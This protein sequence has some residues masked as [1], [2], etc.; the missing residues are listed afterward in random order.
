MIIGEEEADHIVGA[1]I[2]EFGFEDG[3]IVLT[4]DNGRQLQLGA[5]GSRVWFC[6]QEYAVH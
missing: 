4:L 5:S 2:M 6:L 3:C 1:Q